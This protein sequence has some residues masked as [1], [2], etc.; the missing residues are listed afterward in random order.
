MD[1]IQNSIMS[2][3]GFDNLPEDQQAELYQRIGAVLF[4][5]IM[6]SVLD[7]MSDEE[8]EALDKFLGEHPE[9]PEALMG[10]LK[11]HVPDFDRIAAD[12]VARFRASAQDFKDKPLA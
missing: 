3:F 6:I 4:Q 1:P 7:Q 9:D 5:G 12:E 8:Q 10:Y 2:E 11:E